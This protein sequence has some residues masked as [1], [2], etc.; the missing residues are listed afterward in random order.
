MRNKLD[1]SAFGQKN[2]RGVLK[3]K[4]NK[5]HRRLKKTRGVFQLAVVIILMTNYAT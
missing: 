5:E 4:V 1:L 2:N 3:E